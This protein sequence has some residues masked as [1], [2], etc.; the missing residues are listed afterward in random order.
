V[1]VVALVAILLATPAQG[2]AAVPKTRD[3]WAVTAENLIGQLSDLAQV[4]PEEKHYDSFAKLSSAKGKRTPWEDALTWSERLAHYRRGER[5]LWK[6]WLTTGMPP[7]TQ[8]AD[9]TSTAFFRRNAEAYRKYV[10]QHAKLSQDD[11]SRIGL[12]NAVDAFGS[13]LWYMT[14]KYLDQQVSLSHDW[15]IIIHTTPSSVLTRSPLNEAAYRRL[16]AALAHWVKANEGRMV[17]D[18]NRRRFRPS[19]GDYLETEDLF[20][21]IMTET[22]NP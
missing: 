10:N 5:I 17:W 18:E 6:L 15:T 2:E 8:E 12:V 19:S 7:L 11:V 21:V 1:L 16:S 14:L 20:R 22:E 13:P 4:I 9:E 3:D